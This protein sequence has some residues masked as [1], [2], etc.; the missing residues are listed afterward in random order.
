MTTDVFAGVRLAR[1]PV[2]GTKGM[3]VSGHSLAS[4]AGLRTLDKGGSLVDAMISTSAVLSVVLQQ[5]TSLGGDAFFLYHDA[6][7]GK[8]IGL[9]ATGH[10]PDGATE[11]Y[12]KTGIPNRGPNAIS[13][14]GM[15][16]GWERLHEKYGTMEWPDL[17]EDAIDIAEAHPASRV[18]TAGLDLFRNDVMADPGCRALYFRGDK[19][20]RAGEILHQPALAETLNKIASG[21]SAVFYEGEVAQSIGE[22]V[23]ANG[24][25]IGP[26][27]FAK[28]EPEWVDPLATDYRGHTVQVMPPNSYGLLMLMQLNGLSGLTSEKLVDN[29]TDRLDYLIRAMQGAFA[30]GQPYISDPRVVDIP[31]SQLLGV[32]MTKN[33]QDC[34][35][36]GTNPVSFENKGGTSCIVL[37][38]GKGNA[39]SVVQSVFHVFGSAFLDPT[40]GV[41]MNNR[42]TGFRIDPSDPRHVAPRKRPSH[43]LNPVIVMKDGKPKY[44]MTTPGGP[45]Q[46]L[47]MV[48]VLTNLVDRGMELTTAIEYPRWSV[49]LDGNFLLE[50]G[51]TDETAKELERRGHNVQHGSGASYFG[52]AKTIEILDN[53][54]LTGGADTRREAFA[55]GR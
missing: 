15:V 55:A 9:N 7:E 26:E 16:R 39:L 27:Q 50:E 48:Q 20:I 30:L 28:Y 44:L 11:E 8:T 14:P 10:A 54:V 37:A 29:D 13:V 38:D 41:L 19:K 17:F 24:G 35:I 33:L 53:G 3:V 42:M 2:Y 6:A 46:T 22:Y 47:S 45:G 32:D 18:M 51:Y 5:A 34:V 43:T 4:N 52:S 21:K 12:Y 36:N 49:S 31:V 23:R 25:L 1:S 40:T